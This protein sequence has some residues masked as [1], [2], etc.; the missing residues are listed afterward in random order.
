[1]PHACSK[2]CTC[3]ACLRDAGCTCAMHKEEGLYV[4]HAPWRV[5]HLRHASRSGCTR[6]ACIKEEGCTCGLHEGVWA[7]C[8]ACT[9]MGEMPNLVCT[10]Q[11][12]MHAMIASSPAPP[13]P[14]ARHEC[15]G[16]CSPPSCMHATNASRPATPQPV[17]TP[18]RHE[19]LPLP[20]LYAHQKCIRP[21]PLPHPAT[22]ASSPS[23]FFLYAR[24]HFIKPCAPRP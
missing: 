8:L 5:L 2:I 17:C 15:S 3:A 24:H 16:R 10:P 9:N 20:I 23:P 12:C 13:I 18:R 19:A 11:S 14:Y 1:M 7:A 22:S 6:A 21:C 4:W